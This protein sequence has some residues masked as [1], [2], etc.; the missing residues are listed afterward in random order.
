MNMMH[1]RIL[2]HNTTYTHTHTH[3]HTHWS[4]NSDKDDRYNLTR[5]DHI[6]LCVCRSIY[7]SHALEQGGH[8]DINY[9]YVYVCSMEKQY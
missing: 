1:I 8:T 5:I 7:H 4:V 9:V 6:H 3:T 2:I